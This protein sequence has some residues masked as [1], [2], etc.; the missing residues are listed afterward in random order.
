MSFLIA[1]YLTPRTIPDDTSSGPSTSSFS[2]PCNGWEQQVFVHTFGNVIFVDA[3]FCN[4]NLVGDPSSVVSKRK[5][6]NARW[7]IPRGVSWE[8]TW[9]SLFDAE[10]MTLSFVSRTRTVSRSMNWLWDMDASHVIDIDV[11]DDDCDF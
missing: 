3:L 2:I 6:E 7:S 4:S 11:D 9:D 8:K 5:T 10:P 1:A